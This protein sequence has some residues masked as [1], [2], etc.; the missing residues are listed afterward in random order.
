[1]RGFSFV[2]VES[3]FVI[4]AESWSLQVLILVVGFPD[5]GSMTTLP[6]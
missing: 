4:V 3:Q 1:M 2:V 6:N 5:G